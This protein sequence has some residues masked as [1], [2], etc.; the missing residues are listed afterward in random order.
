M[1]DAAGTAIGDIDR[2]RYEFRTK[3]KHAVK[4]E[5]GLSERTV[6]ELSE[7]KKEPKWMLE[8]RLKSFAEFQRRPVPKWGA[9]L[10]GI[11]FNEISYYL[12]PEGQQAR[13][14]EDVPAEIKETFEKLG[15]PEAERK[16]LAGSLAQF[17]S[18]SIY[19]NLKKQWEEKGVIFTDMDSALRK[20]P[21]IV[22]K[23]FL[24]AVPYT[25]NKFAALHGAV[26]SGGTFLYV[27]DGVRIDLPLQN[28][29][30]MN[31]AREGMFEHTMLIL[32]KG[33]KAH[34]T[35]GCS[36]PRY[37]EASVHSAIIEIFVGEG[38]DAGYTSVQNWSKNV[39]NLNT[40]RA[41]VEKNGRM[42]W[43]DG[44]LGSK[45]T[46]L[47]PM[48]VLRGEGASASNYNM[49][50]SSQGSWKDTG[51]KVVHAAPN[52]TSKVVAK[53]ICM[54]GGN[55]SYRGLV[56]INKGALNAKSAVQCDALILD[57]ISKTD[58]YPH[59]E[60]YEPSATVSHEATV[61]RISEDHL[62]YLMSR[63]LNEEEAK[64]MIVLGFLEEVL[65]EVPL[66][67]SVEFNRLVKLEFSKLGAV[68]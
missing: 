49:T 66:E 68:G 33:S 14:W 27:P 40:K 10:G 19:Q 36:A 51:A 48:S 56:H 35:E 18:E 4:F 23:H 46:M 53:S 41:L 55:A 29:F 34:Y 37:E 54:T 42:Q 16:Y 52:T 45:V 17:Q 61:G 57:E 59:N 58:T 11:N 38:A 20:Y 12:K 3:E 22:R 28:Y 21:E 25:D 43:V 24:R 13:N 67:Y 47:Y 62:F 7:L 9:D 30:R 60:I 26:W 1:A 8:L 63:G 5:E 15:V 44:S 31:S 2:A 6:R 39:Y 50:F 64:S 32:G 65:K